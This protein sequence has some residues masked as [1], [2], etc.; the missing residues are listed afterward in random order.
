M[1]PIMRVIEQKRLDLTPKGK[2]LADF[3][4]SN[5]GK[6]VFM[7][8]REL[9]ETC[10]VSEAT[11][12]RFV[13]QLGYSGYSPFIQ[14]LKDLLDTELNLIDR[15]DLTDK[16]GPGADRFQRV[17]FEEIDNLKLLLE[18]MDLTKIDRV[19]EMLYLNPSVFVVGSRLSYTLAYYLGW[20][21][22][23][24]RTNALTLKGSDSTTLDMLTFAP[25]NSLVVAIATTRYPNDLIR[26]GKFSKRLNHRL[27]VLTDSSACP[28]I[29]FADESLVAPLKN[30]PF[31][32]SPTAI[33]CLINFIIQ[34]LA[35]KKGPSLKP[36]QQ[37]LEKTY[38]ENDVLFNMKVET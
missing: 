2:R 13:G 4:V 27:V 35:A 33:G 21:L 30:I 29:P 18:S 16:R 19:V 17:V 26:I 37:K 32:G 14:A 23:K 3:V 10:H 25:E 36:H 6:A 8:V 15:L 28:L 24:I 38:R 7:T 9:A 31:I 11:V 1:P 12:V 34:E 5:P 22:T 20:S